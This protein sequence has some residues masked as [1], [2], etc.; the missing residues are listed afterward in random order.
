V[1]H[2]ALAA[3]SST[4]GLVDEKGR[5]YLQ[6]KLLLKLLITLVIS[7]C[8]FGQGTT[9]LTGT[10]T[11]PSGAVVPAATLVLENVATGVSREVASDQNGSYNFAMVAPGLTVERQE[12]RFNDL[13]I[14]DI[15]LR[16]NTPVSVN[17]KFEKLGTVSEVISVTAE[18]TQVNTVDATI[19]NNF[20]TK[21][22]LHLPFEGRNVVS[23]L[24]LQPGVTFL[25][26]NDSVNGDYR[27]V[28]LTAARATRPT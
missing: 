18:G 1:F 9:S 6:P 13:I 14:N 22:I 20:G 11:D 15:V 7:L 25:G 21:P 2:P 24:S 19:G 26:D 12:E 5:F 16:V 28:R 17:P 3:L 10:V 8:A 23:L 27:Q 4:V